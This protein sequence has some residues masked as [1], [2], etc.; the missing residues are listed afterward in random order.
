VV[1]VTGATTRLAALVLVALAVVFAARWV[2]PEAPALYDGGIQATPPYQYCD[3][4]PDLR[5]SNKPPSGGSGDLPAV[6]GV[7]KIGTVETGDKQVVAFFAQGVFKISSGSVH[8]TIDPVC[9]SPPPPPPHSTRIGNDYRITAS[10]NSPGATPSPPP[11]AMPAQ[12]LLRVPPVAY[13]TVRVHYDGSWHDTQFGAQLDL[14]NISLD[15]LG[16][17]AAFN[18]TSLKTPAKPPS[19]FNFAAVFEIVLTV[20]ALLIIVAGIVAQRRRSAAARR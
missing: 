2:T 5:S 13:N 15:H 19:T 17:I 12:I 1:A 11:L 6:G 14:V 3:P 20:A 9:T 10:I 7:N 8:L 16:D 18:D 4:P